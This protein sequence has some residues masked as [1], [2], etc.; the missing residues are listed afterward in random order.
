MVDIYIIF[1]IIKELLPAILFFVIGL[2]TFIS[3][4]S[5]ASKMER[6]TKY[7]SSIGFNRYL[8]DVASVGNRAWYGWERNELNERIS[9]TELKKLTLKELKNR[10]K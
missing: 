5:Q 4:A 2:I 8:I 7:L 9:E 3:I 6:K 10:F 1:K